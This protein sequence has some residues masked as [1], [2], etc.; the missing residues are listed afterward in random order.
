MYGKFTDCP[1]CKQE[2]EVTFDVVNEGRVEGYEQKCP[3]CN[4]YFLVK[5]MFYTEMS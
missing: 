4:E 1:H 3:N 2:T 5:I